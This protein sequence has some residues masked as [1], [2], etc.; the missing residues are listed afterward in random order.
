[1]S[2]NLLALDTST[3]RAVLALQ[4]SDGRVLVAPPADSAR[5]HASGLVPAISRLLREAGLGPGDLDALAVGLGPG[6]Y[7]GLR[8]GIT[9]ARTLAYALDRPLVGLDSLEAIARDAPAEARRIVVVADAQR[10][11][12]YVAGFGR[13]GPDR[14]P[15]RIGPTRI[16]P[17]VD[18]I[19]SLQE[20]AYVA[21]PGLDRLGVVLPG[22]VEVAGPEGR[23]PAG[24]GLIALASEALADGRQDD[25]G[26][27][28]PFYLRRSSAEDKW[29]ARPAPGT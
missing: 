1:M 4:R 15:S 24:P 5:R 25:P 2:G 26:V 27:L 29:D 23:L 7:T 6:S 10:G 19:A 13:V 12:L 3:L 20:G 8:V 9:A 28:E 17:S 18:W 22:T 11:D 14:P 16:V 21:G